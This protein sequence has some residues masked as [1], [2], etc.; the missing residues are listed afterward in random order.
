MVRVYERV[1]KQ[2]GEKRMNKKR[3]KQIKVLGEPKKNI[4]FK[5]ELSLIEQLRREGER[6]GVSYADI[7]RIGLIRELKRENRTIRD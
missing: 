4:T 6:R 3:L 5:L 1:K 7:V 2:K